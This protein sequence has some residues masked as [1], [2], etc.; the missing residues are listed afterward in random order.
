MR[1]TMSELLNF[2][3]DHP[4]FR[5]T[6]LP[7][8]YSDFRNLQ[9]TNSSAFT[10]NVAAWKRLLID[11]TAHG[12]VGDGTDKLVITTGEALVTQ[13]SMQ[14]WGRPLALGVVVNE[15]IHAKE[16]YPV[17]T[18][19]SQRESIY[20]WSYAG[21]VMNWGLEKVGLKSK[22]ATSGRAR[23][24]EGK[25]VVIKNVENTAR[26]V[27]RKTNQK[28]SQVE[29]IYTTDLFIEE[30]APGMSQIDLKVL[31]R[32][33]AR[34]LGEASY[35]GKIIKFKI[36]G[37]QLSPVNE[38]DITIAQ[39]RSLI[40]TLQRRI[41]KLNLDVSTCNE[42]ARTAVA[43]KNRLMATAA[44]KSR[45]I[46]EN[47]LDTQIKTLSQVEDVMAHIEQ[48]TS[49]LDLVN[50]LEKSTKVLNTL[51]KEIGGTERVDRIMDDLKE[52]TAQVDELNQVL[53]EGG[54]VLDEA[55][56]DEELEALFMEE[57]TKAR[58]ERE[59]AKIAGADLKDTQKHVS[60]EPEAQKNNMMPAS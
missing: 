29:R 47:A 53:G 33:L 27:L 36:Q 19:L 10:A 23:I 49:N 15:A 22:P 39:L 60:P 38:Q 37:E 51:N 52:S 9:T 56:V 40:S 32:F 11:A 25:F 1:P 50:Q 12:L 18:F 13:M 31:F 43:S 3:L 30:L 21:A 57:D 59:V 2:V 7:S 28:T 55:D 14:E 17:N 54:A 26:D 16:L 5:K 8:L 4:D 34:D 6:R 24:T 48:A 58:R 35:N 44:L 41:E 42:K 45:K 20:Y 46:A